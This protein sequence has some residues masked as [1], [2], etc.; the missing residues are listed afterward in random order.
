M[1]SQHLPRLF[2]SDQI[3]SSDQK[4]TTVARV[5]VKEWIVRFGVPKRIHSDQ[6]WNFESKVVQELCKI[7]G[8]TKS[9]TSP[10]HPEGNGQ[11]ERFNR[12]M[13]HHLPTL[14]PE[15]KCRWPEFLSESVFAYNC[16]PHLT[17]GYSYLF[18]GKGPTLPA[19]HIP[20][21][22]SQVEGECSEWITE[23]Q[24]C[25]EKAFRLASV[26]TEKEAL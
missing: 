14:S 7:Y 15:R 13:Y 4:A 11:C 25:L 24:Q 5:L 21:S 9:H 19:D 17:T 12:T 6:R 10:H 1:F 8:I 16:T 3:R 22:A 23:H 20:G 26:K 18:F 2:Q